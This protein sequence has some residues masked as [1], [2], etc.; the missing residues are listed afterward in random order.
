CDETSAAVVR[1]PHQGAVDLLSNVVA[2]QDDLHAHFG[3]IVPEVASRRHVEMIAPV[4]AEALQRSQA[5]WSD[6]DAIAVAIGP[7]LIG[8]LVVGVAA[9]QAF[10]VARDLPLV[11]VHH[12][13]GHIYSATI[14]GAL[15]LPAVVL[16]ASGGHSH[17]VLMRDHGQYEIL[18]RTRDDAPGEAFDKGARLLG[19]PYPG[20]PQLAAL[21]DSHRGRVDPLPRAQMPGSRDFSFSGV[22][23]ALARVVREEELT[24]ARRA[25]LA[26]A[27]QESIALS[28][29]E[30]VVAAA[31]DLGYLPI[32]LVGGVARNRRLRELLGEL[33][34]ER[35]LPVSFP[36]PEF[37]TD[38]GAMIAAAGVHKPPFKQLYSPSANLPLTSW[39]ARAGT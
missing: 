27:Y 9:A 35:G 34:T 15:P 22:K 11:G 31:E 5:S 32:V 23:T 20:G 2:S 24:D 26:A 28:L 1:G 8:S 6:L 16:I 13:E 10:A 29:A 30:G 14:G 36:A 25:E 37:C 17:L 19:L 3:G 33:A 4:V 21:A 12:L 38:N 7:G 39:S 18:G